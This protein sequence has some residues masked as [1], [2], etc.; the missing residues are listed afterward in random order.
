M[1]GRERVRRP[2]LLMMVIGLGFIAIG[3]GVI[4][5]GAFSHGTR[6]TLIVFGAVVF[7][8]GGLVSMWTLTEWL[9]YRAAARQT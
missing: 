6:N 3:I 7:M 8:V 9:K 4:A 2:M 5:F 1:N